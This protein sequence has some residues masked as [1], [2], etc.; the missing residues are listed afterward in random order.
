MEIV[1]NGAPRQVQSTLSLR[2]LLESLHLPT[3]EAGIA[4]SVNG[5]LVRK[6]EWPALALKARDEIEIV[7]ATQGG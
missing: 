4:V 5:E 6:A 1:V 3:L 7:Q 2:Q